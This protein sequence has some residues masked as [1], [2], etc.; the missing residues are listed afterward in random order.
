MKCDKDGIWADLVHKAVDSMEIPLD[1]EN[2][3]CECS[4]SLRG[5]SSV[6]GYS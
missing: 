1:L 6:K 4:E 5:V 3:P 2:V